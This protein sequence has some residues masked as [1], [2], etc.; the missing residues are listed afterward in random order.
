MKSSILLWVPI[1]LALS[2]TGQILA[3]ADAKGETS[4]DTKTVSVTGCL[5]QSDS[6]GVAKQY[7]IKSGDM[8]YALEAG[9]ENLSAHLGHKVT[10]S[11]TSMKGKGPHDDDRI[12][13]TKL[14]TISATCP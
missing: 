14:V 9:T 5:A 2:V 13:V 4:K 11:G 6:P 10:I 7:I 8:S 12:S 3:Q 1:A